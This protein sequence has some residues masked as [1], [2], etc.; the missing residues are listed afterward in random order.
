MKTKQQMQDNEYLTI[1]EAAKIFLK[2]NGKIGCERSQIYDMIHRE[3]IPIETVLLLCGRYYIE[4]E[5][6]IENFTKK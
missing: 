3:V 4:K 2:K 6:F 5:Y 1:T